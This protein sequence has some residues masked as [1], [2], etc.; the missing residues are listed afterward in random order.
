[1]TKTTLERLMEYPHSAVFDKDPEASLAFRLRHQDVSSW[2][3]AEGILTVT[4]D[5]QAF[6]FDLSQYT[7]G[8]LTNALVDAGFEIPY[9]ASKHSRLGA[10][11]LIEGS[12]TEAQSNGDHLYVFESPL[13]AILSGY[14]GELR[15][16][17]YQAEQALRQMV[18][19][20]SDGEWLELW[21]S[22][23]ATG[24]LD[25]ETDG[26]FAPRIPKEA[27]RLR[28][29]GLAI[30]E[31]IKDITGKDVEIREPWRYVFR[32]S[33]SQLSGTHRFPDENYYGYFLIHPISRVPIDWDD[34]LGV[35][36]RNRAAGIEVYAPMVDFEVRHVPM[37]PP[38]EYAVD[39]GIEFL[40]SMRAWVHGD[41]PL[42]EMILDDNEF[43]FNHPVILYHLYSLSNRSGLEMMQVEGDSLNLDFVLNVSLFP[44]REDKIIAVHHFVRGSIILSDGDPLGDENAIFSRGMVTWETDPPAT[45][46]DG[47]A[48][49]DYESIRHEH[50]VEQ[51]FMD[52]H[53]LPVYA[54][55]ALDDLGFI[56]RGDAR[57]AYAFR[58]D[59]SVWNGE[60]VGMAMSEES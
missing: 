24:R 55:D 56:G 47:L 2:S 10:L 51:I 21:G 50:L 17:A 6:E 5:E 4:A 33:E 49:S 45:T 8:S 48:L 43:T 54:S 3:V 22:L 26:E 53:Y 14:T 18:I 37:S 30:E 38:V 11:A 46:S 12:G 60:V 44:G 1:M 19:W 25:G 36:H 16:A 23:Y 32:L 27:F 39:M 31:A 13:W 20:Q 42:G 58:V 29:N 34:V 15:E 52:M 41:A 35:I 57:S 59:D 40:H 7:I 28:V 9:I